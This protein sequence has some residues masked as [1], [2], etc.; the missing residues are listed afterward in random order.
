MGSQLIVDKEV[1][2]CV[3][4]DGTLIK[5]DLLLESII[6]LVK[7]NPFYLIISIGWLLKGKAYFKSEVA[8]QIN[9]LP[10]SL[11]YNTEIVE[12]IKKDN[13]HLLLVTGSNIKFAEC[14]AEH[15]GIF[16]EVIASDAITNVTKSN[17]LKIL[18]NRFGQ[19]GFDYI[20]NDRDDWSVWPAAR[21]VLVVAKE[22][23]FLKKTRNKF[24][25]DEEFL[26]P[27][28]S[29]RSFIKAIRAH[30]WVKNLLIFVPFLLEHSYNDLQSFL[31][32]ALGFVS[33]SLLASLTYIVNDLLD[34]EADRTNK[35]K[36]LRAFASGLI[37]VKQALLIMTALVL[38]VF[39]IAAQL[40]MLFQLILCAYFLSTLSYSFLFKR[41]A[42]LDVCVL[43][44]LYTLRI[45]G[46]SV[47]INAEWS[48]WL[49]AFSMFFF[50]SLALAK[51]VSELEN[52][53]QEQGLFPVGRGYQVVDLPMLTSTGVSSGL[54]S[55]LVVALYINSEKVEQMYQYPQ[56]LWL[57]C[58]L[59]LYWI[60]RVWMIT[61]RGKMHE[62][63]ILFAIRDRV[64]MF[65]AAIAGLVVIG[66]VF[67]PKLFS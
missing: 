45:V 14:V 30:Q 46:G 54:L 13:R 67:L 5:T 53:K 64:S 56:I 20:G 42:I 10:A 55:I 26:L 38:L 24:T 31:I 18:V 9:I 19:K 62:D 51:R 25:I 27:K 61:A 41:V 63:P 57:I 36:R 49:L 35:V 60:G 32:V 50:L 22:G 66:A 6:Q 44:S 33:M 58:P 23:G 43:A 21:R 16:D 1:P 40:P 37:S 15:L 47:V 34:L 3:D 65:T 17:K 59:L 29:F 4:L 8:K 11:P 7:R 48:F 39:M 28:I 52:I 2:L 12:Y